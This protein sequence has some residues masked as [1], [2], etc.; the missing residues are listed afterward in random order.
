MRSD[1]NLIPPVTG[2]SIRWAQLKKI[3]VLAVIKVLRFSRKVFRRQIITGNI[4]GRW[5]DSLTSF[6][7]CYKSINPVTNQLRPQLV[8]IASQSPQ[9]ILTITINMHF[10]WTFYLNQQKQKQKQTLY[11]AKLFETTTKTRINMDLLIN[12]LLHRMSYVSFKTVRISCRTPRSCQYLWIICVSLS[13]VN[14]IHVQSPQM[15]IPSWQQCGLCD[16]I[17]DMLKW[18]VIS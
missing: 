17:F 7:S 11:G 16:P 8:V 5:E 15:L 6:L 14:N 10:E 12:D 2:R 13:N 9:Q 3:E 4:W 18:S 1:Y